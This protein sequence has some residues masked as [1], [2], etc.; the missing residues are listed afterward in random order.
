MSAVIAVPELMADAAKDL[1]T[2]G[3]RIGA[4]HL[5]AAAPTL[6]VLPAAADEV[7]TS[8]AHLFSQHAADYQGL[9]GEAAAVQEQF[10]QHLTAGAVSYA[11]AEATNAASLRPLTA[12]AGA[13][14]SA[15]APV[16]DQLGNL[17]ASINAT[18]GELFNML[19]SKVIALLNTLYFFANV[20]Y[21]LAFL[22]YVLGYFLA[23]FGPL[24]VLGVPILI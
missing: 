9:A 7:S 3:S 18:W 8:I 17:L 21:I 14:A 2:I 20:L 12:M 5:V 6:S 11:S 1:A 16:Q 19:A 22:V 24:Y 10:V 13:S 23:Q 15:I 4:A